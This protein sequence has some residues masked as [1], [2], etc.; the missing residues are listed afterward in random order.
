MPSGVHVAALLR[1]EQFS[2]QMRMAIEFRSNG[3]GLVVKMPLMCI[4]S[5]AGLR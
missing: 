4:L 5:R 1:I 3:D 2:A